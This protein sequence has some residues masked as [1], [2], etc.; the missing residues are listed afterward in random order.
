MTQRIDITFFDSYSNNEELKTIHIDNENFYF[1]F[2][3]YD[4]DGNPFIDETIYYAK[5]Y[6]NEDDMKELPLE[7]CNIEK[8]GSKYKNLIGDYSLNDYY[9]LVNVN[10][11]ITTYYG[12]FIIKI[13][14]CKNTTENNNH[15]KPKEIIDKYLDGNVF[16]VAFEDILIT[17]LNYENPIKEQINKL[18]TNV[19]KTFGQYMFVE[20]ELVKIETSTNIIGF[21]F[22]TKPK[23][24]D[25]IKYYSLEIIPEPGYNLDDEKNDYPIC[26]VEFAL[27]DKIL[28]E[29]R[30]YIQ[31]LDMLGE[32]GGLM[33]FLSSFFGLICN[34][35]GDLL[36]DK[37]IAN[38]LFSF[39][40]K[41]K[42]ILIKRRNNFIHN[43]IQDKTKEKV[44]LYN[45][46]EFSNNSN[47]HK[48]AGKK[49]AFMDD[50][51]REITS[52]DSKNSS[53]RKKN[54][55]ENQIYQNDIEI[56]KK[57]NKELY[58]KDIIYSNN[59]KLADI[60]STAKKTISLRN[61]NKNEYL[62]DIINLKDLFISIRFC[63]SRKR[64][65][66]YKILLNE[67]KEIV[68]EKLDIFNIF[69]DLCSIEDIKKNSDDNIINI[70]MSDN[71]SNYLREKKL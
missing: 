34:I 14:P 57:A 1:F 11:T 18:Y 61:N 38:N 27:N 12:S 56:D 68:T 36:Y 30:Q 42:V 21:D 15:C 63:F 46:K 28:V 2:A 44:S 53:T 35:I 6:Y 7:R 4:G 67:T 64:K 20:M 65:N 48:K 10:Y 5:A 22:L 69:R 54:L 13:F 52:N 41:N 37:T 58:K 19:F 32:I 66:I 39:D 51:I 43:F 55:L 29:K 33:E 31:F 3:V 50:N 26:E 25:F 16:M 17:P 60:F 59:K 40:I 8:L 62:I 71:C 45:I 23:T 24:E 9:A 70:N 47:N 49:L